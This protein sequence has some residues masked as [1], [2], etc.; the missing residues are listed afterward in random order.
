MELQR[1]LLP[2]TL[3]EWLECQI[4]S[5]KKL[6]KKLNGYQK[7]MKMLSEIGSKSEAF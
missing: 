7:N 4:K 6:T 5:Y 2:T 1:S 3:H